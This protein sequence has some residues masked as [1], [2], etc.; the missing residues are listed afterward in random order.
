MTRSLGESSK[1]SESRSEVCWRSHVALFTN[2]MESLTRIFI[3]EKGWNV[4]DT[5]NLN[6]ACLDY[7][8]TRVHV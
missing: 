3:S 6:G 8:K 4:I 1:T 2:E 7:I 5:N